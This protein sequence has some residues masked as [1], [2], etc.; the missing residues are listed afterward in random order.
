MDATEPETS[1][2]K[3]LDLNFVRLDLLKLGIE[4]LKDQERLAI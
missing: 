2:R 3:D 4:A 1:I